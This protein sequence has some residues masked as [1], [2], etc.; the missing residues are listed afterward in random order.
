MILLALLTSRKKQQ[1]YSTNETVYFAT[2]S[3]S[4]NPLSPLR[5]ANLVGLKEIAPH[6]IPFEK[7]ETYNLCIHIIV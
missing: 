4:D 6:S 1:L 3:N 5:Q 2:E 7:K